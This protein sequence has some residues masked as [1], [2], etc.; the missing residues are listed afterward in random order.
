MKQELVF[1]FMHDGYK[2]TLLSLLSIL[3]LT[4]GVINEQTLRIPIV[5][6]LINEA[7]EQIFVV[8]LNVSDASVSSG[9][10]ISWASSLCKIVDNDRKLYK[11]LLS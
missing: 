2:Y 1:I 7:V 6:D 8:I 10:R 3:T 4:E 11:S 9:Y 5:D